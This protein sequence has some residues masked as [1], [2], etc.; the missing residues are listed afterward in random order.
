MTHP[1]GVIDPGSDPVQAINFSELI[2]QLGSD[3][4]ICNLAT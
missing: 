3:K 1:A 4:L 2:T